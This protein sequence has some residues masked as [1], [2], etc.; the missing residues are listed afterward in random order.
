MADSS[1]QNTND[2]GGGNDSFK[3][4]SKELESIRNEIA[5]YTRPDKDAPIEEQRE[6]KDRKSVV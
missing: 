4:I 2:S 1:S 6:F 3:S 5:E